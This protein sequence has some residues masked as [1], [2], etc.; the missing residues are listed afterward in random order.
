MC[1][2]SGGRMLCVERKGA[3][4]IDGR[5]EGVAIVMCWQAF[6]GG[7]RVVVCG[8]VFRMGD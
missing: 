6:L 8:E 1:D 3:G 2:V 4:G 7:G 5:F